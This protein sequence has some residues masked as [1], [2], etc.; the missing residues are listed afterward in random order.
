MKK[1]ILNRLFALERLC[2]FVEEK[3]L[4][5]NNEG[6]TKMSSNKRSRST[7]QAIFEWISA[8]IQALSPEAAEETRVR[9]SKEVMEREN[10]WVPA[11]QLFR[12]EAELK[13]EID[14]LLQRMSSSQNRYAY[15][16]WRYRR[17]LGLRGLGWGPQCMGFPKKGGPEK[18][19]RNLKQNERKLNRTGSI[20]FRITRSG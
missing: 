19:A 5:L 7:I 12:K 4:L 14:A 8:Q 15:F 3:L 11:D 20:Q 9:N 6:F 2:G 13:P 18:T 10:R 17:E 1:T 16:L